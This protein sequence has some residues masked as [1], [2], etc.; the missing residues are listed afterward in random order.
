[1]IIWNR[2]FTGKEG[3]AIKFAM[4]PHRKQTG[5]VIKGGSTGQEEDS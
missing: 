4:T 2:N 3:I 5:N 1:M